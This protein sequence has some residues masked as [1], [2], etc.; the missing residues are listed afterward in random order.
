MDLEVARGYAQLFN[1]I[2]HFP[3]KIVVQAGVIETRTIDTVNM[4][5]LKKLIQISPGV[6]LTLAHQFQ[7]NLFRQVLQ[8]RSCQPPMLI[9]MSTSRFRAH[10]T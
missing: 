6:C 3:A 2:V 1:T 9:E 10:A 7:Y 4:K 8:M 5:S